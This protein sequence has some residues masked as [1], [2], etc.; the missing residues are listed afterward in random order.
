MIEAF[1][2]V[3]REKNMV[4]L[5]EYKDRS[6][7]GKNVILYK[8]GFFGNKITPHR[9]M[10]NTSH[11][12]QKQGYTIC[13]FDCVGAGDSE[14]DSHYTTIYG[15]IED[16]RVVLHWIADKLQPDKLMILGYSM[17]G[18]V[19]SVL[20]HEVPLEGI[21]LW[22]PCS[23]P[24]SNFRHLLG[25]DLFIKG[26]AGNDVDFMGDLVP[27]EFFVGLDDKSIDPL[28]AIKG[29]KK[30]LR[31]IQ[32]DG[33]QDVSVSNSARYEEAVP[34]AKRH[35]ISGATHGYDQISWQR[36]LL[37]YTKKYVKD[38]MGD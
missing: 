18:I 13:R 30:P 10:V 1:T 28:S 31:L 20:C 21:L 35:I 36:E 11:E 34:G 4:C 12:L 16:T 19:T 26:V 15:E 7:R 6:V 25:E 2:L 17:G 37:A 27:K 32:G 22:S 9:I 23:N 33:D 38:I 24:Y 29:F 14:G 3:S 5:L 8:H